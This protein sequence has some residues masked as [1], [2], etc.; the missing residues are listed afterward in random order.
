M[1]AHLDAVARIA[2]AHSLRLAAR[3]AT[4]VAALLEAGIAAT[5][6]KGL[7]VVARAHALPQ[8]AMGDVDILVGE[9]DLSAAIA[10]LANIGFRLELPGSLHEYTEFIRHAPHFSGNRA[11]AL[12][13]DNGNS[14]DLHWG[15]GVMCGRSLAT[16]DV[17]R[18]SVASQLFGQSVR[19]V[20]RTD[21][22]LLTA[23]HAMRENFA[24]AA[25]VRN[26]LD[27][28]AFADHACDE[29]IDLEVLADAGAPN[30]ALAACLK[31]LD[32]H[33]DPRVNRPWAEPLVQR[34]SPAQ[35]RQCR[36]LAEIFDSQL[37]APPLNRDVLHLLHGATLRG[38]LQTAF[39]HTRRN[40]RFMQAIDGAPDRQRLW[41]LLAAL[42]RLRP[43]HL[44]LY[45]SLARA[46]QSAADVQMR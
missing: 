8:R 26:L 32:R 33:A 7:A 43:H 36:D 3:G 29:T 9:A 25:T 13:D 40:R 23:H 38:I 30:I 12:V 42:C 34:L 10:T 19:R 1:A 22:L 2:A 21:G 6:F 45:R 20:S 18:R 27:I 14:L 41:R 44:R 5:G 46:K 35:Q 28:A 39:V 16:A 24:P 37:D 15:F 4:A 11:V 17:L 31:I